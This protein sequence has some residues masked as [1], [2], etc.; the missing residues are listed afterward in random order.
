MTDTYFNDTVFIPGPSFHVDLPPIDARHM[1]H[2]SRRLLIF[3]CTSSAQRDAQLAAFKTGIHALLQRCPILGGV[4]TPLPPD[5]ASED[6]KDWRT[7]VPDR[8]IELV[9]KDLRGSAIPSFEELEAAN[10]PPLHFPW[11]LLMPIPQDLS[12]ERPHA[13]CK[14]QFSAIEGGTILTFA[15]SHCVSDGGGTDEWTRILIEETRLAQEDST[16]NRAKIEVVGLDRSVLCNMRSD[17][18]FNIHD[19]PAY[20]FKTP[21]AAETAP[22]PAPSTVNVFGATSAKIPVLL[23]L[24]P[25]GLAQLKADATTP[26]APPISTHDALCSLMWRTILLIRSRRSPAAQAV[27]PS[28][29]SNL[30]MP[31]NA[32]RYLPALPSPYIG[33]AVYQIIAAL[34]LGTLLSPSGLQRA[35]LQVRA[36]ITSVT[37]ARVQSYMAFLTD[38]TASRDI[39]YQFMNGT[40]DTTGYA[41]GT[42]LGSGEAMYGSDWGKA[43]GKMERFRLIGEPGN[44]VLPRLPDGSAEV[45]VAVMPEEVGVLKGAEGF[46]KY[47]AQ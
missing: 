3:R 45:V 20:R 30:F 7:I 46:G 12:N 35:A 24:S 22:E 40:T 23:R 19:H 5:A 15:M 11:D 34:D 4:V 31:S 29:I 27:P 41:M 28:T 18:E 16:E 13:A 1:F 25:A 42:C 10:F 33:N 21:P 2:F 39:D 32:R 37:T 44:V 9:V 8:G 47:L 38:L 26:G 36:A 14:L 43:F 6:K 17:V